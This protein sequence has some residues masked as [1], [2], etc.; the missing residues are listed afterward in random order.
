MKKVA[1]IGIVTADVLVKPVDAIPPAGTLVTTESAAMHVGGCAANAAADLCRLGVPSRLIAKLG[2]DSFG[3]FIEQYLAERRVPM[4]DVVHDETVATSVSMVCIASGGERSFLYH[5][6]CNDA[7]EASDIPAERIT[8]CDIVFIA[9][10]LLMERFDGEP[11]AA[12]LRQC[13][14]QGKTTVLDTAWDSRGQWMAKLAP[15]LPYLD[16]FMPSYDEAVQLS[17]ERDPSRQA[18]QFHACGARE[19]IIKLGGDG[20][21]FREEGGESY[22]LPTYRTI[23]PVDTTGAGDAFC[24]GL[25]AGLAQGWSLRESG[26]LANAVGT[27]CITAIGA[28]EGIRPLAE[29]EAFMRAHPLAD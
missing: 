9:G 11:C 24:A 26:R 3:R 29:I 10:A 20:A 27:H 22:R 19:V 17:G 18:D 7:F 2:R 6:G 16:L 28:V 1:C 5:P 14:V 15:C 13:R 8:D 25:L 4:E 21:F 23:K 12:F